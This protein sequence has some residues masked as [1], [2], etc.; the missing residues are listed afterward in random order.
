MIIHLE[1]KKNLKLNEIRIS[2]LIRAREFCGELPIARGYIKVPT[3]KDS[4]YTNEGYWKVK[5]NL[6]ADVISFAAAGGSY[7]GVAG[8]LNPMIWKNAYEVDAT[9]LTFGER[10]SLTNQWNQWKPGISIAREFPNINK[11]TIVRGDYVDYWGRHFSNGNI[12]LNFQAFYQYPK[13][14]PATVSHEAIENIIYK[15]FSAEELVTRYGFEDYGKQETIVESLNVK[16]M[17]NELFKKSFSESVKA[18]TDNLKIN[19]E[20]GL[21]YLPDEYIEIHAK[22]LAVLKNTNYNEYLKLKSVLSKL[23]NYDDI[24]LKLEEYNKVFNTDWS[25]LIG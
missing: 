10:I 23:N 14:I 7:A 18:D 1:N 21:T 22:N 20:N 12:R 4:Y 15:K 8:K 5:E 3:E 9:K 19:M 13:A 6:N 25:F 17:D 2:D 24:L 11:I 16:Y